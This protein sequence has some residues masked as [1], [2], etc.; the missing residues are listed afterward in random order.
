MSRA[1]RGRWYVVALFFFFLFPFF[2]F[3]VDLDLDLEVCC[4]LDLL[5]IVCWHVMGVANYLV[6]AVDWN[7]GKV[8][9]GENESEILKMLNDLTK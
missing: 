1:C 7:N 6:Q 9:A 2:F 8:A 5:L 4:C 3:L